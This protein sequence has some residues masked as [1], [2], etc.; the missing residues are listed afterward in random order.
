MSD[1][2]LDPEFLD[3]LTDEFIAEMNSVELDVL[4]ELLLTEH[5][6]PG[7]RGLQPHQL[8]PPEWAAGELYA[9]LFQAG[10]GAGKT[11]AMSES[12]YEHVNGP[13]C[14]PWEPG[15]HR[16]AIVAPTLGDVAIS[17]WAGPSGLR[18]IDPRIRM[19]SRRGGTFV[20]F[21]NG[22]EAKCA[23]AATEADTERL[24]AAGNVCFAWVEEAAACRRL[25]LVWRQ[26][27]FAVRH[28]PSPRVQMSSTPKPTAAFKRIRASHRVGIT[29][30]RTLDNVHLPESERQR[31]YEDHEGTR[32]GRQELE[33]EMIDDVPGAHWTAD[34]VDE[35][36]LLTPQLRTSYPP[37]DETRE[38]WLKRVLK[39]TTVYV[40][41]DPGTS[42]RGD[43]TGIIV[44][45]GDNPK[46]RPDGKRHVFFLEDRT[47]LMVP[48]TVD[49]GE[50]LGD[51]HLPDDIEGWAGVAAE[52]AIR[53]GAH[54]MV[55]ERNRLGRTARAVLRAGGFTGRIIEVDAVGDKSMR[56]D[57]LRQVWR[58]R[59]WI[60]D[61][62]EH[63][64]TEMTQWVPAEGDKPEFDPEQDDV[65]EFTGSP[66]ALDAAGHPA[67]LLL[68]IGQPQT[69]PSEPLTDALLAGWDNNYLAPQF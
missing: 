49:F 50:A 42:G 39:L 52:A 14:D 28:G 59:C 34:V 17:C 69:L 60:V 9:W 58:R 7:R 29:R 5:V 35:R 25:A 66:D 51:E 27:Q 21:P 13:P 33:G 45:G 1:L 30:A 55:V 65:S 46:A 32:L 67:R 16:M 10:R 44:V 40:G 23:G 37:G 15:G 68:G 3:L 18:R 11:L 64:E 61:T 57:A 19:T 62:L 26:L 41:I 53:W 2:L 43:R 38:Q 63:L 47:G 31:L 6:V 48:S 36:R 20:I 12:M 54:A 56:A 22:A 24:R 4:L 8:P